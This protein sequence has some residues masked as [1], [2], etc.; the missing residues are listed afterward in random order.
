MGLSDSVL[1]AGLFSTDDTFLNCMSPK[2]KKTKKLKDEPPSVESE[3]VPPIA[4]AAVKQSKKRRDSFIPMP[5]RRKSIVSQPS[6]V[7]AADNDDAVFSE[8]RPVVKPSVVSSRRMSV[9]GYNRSAPIALIVP[10]AASVASSS[11]EKREPM[12][13]K[14]AK[15]RRTS[16]AVGAQENVDPQQGQGNIFSKGFKMISQ[17]FKFGSG[18]TE[19]QDDCDSKSIA[20][21]KS[22][23]LHSAN[24]NTM[25]I[26]VDDTT[27]PKITRTSNRRK[28]I[29]VSNP[30]TQSTDMWKDI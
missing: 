8:N 11:E 10:A 20:A 7:L 15:S 23:P 13:T 25:N 26:A 21:K 30:R 12:E 22:K 2:V 3:A 1:A 19:V 16:L 9:G 29:A 4:V 28:S 6:A 24:T 5:S 17:G 18:K 14:T 27:Q